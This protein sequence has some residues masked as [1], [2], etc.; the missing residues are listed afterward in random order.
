MKRETVHFDDEIVLRGD[1]YWYRGKPDFANA[2]IEKSLKIKKGALQKDVLRAKREFLLAEENR[3][4]IKGKTDFGYIRE[5]YIEERELEG[6]AHKTIW[7]IRHVMREHFRYFEKYR[8][9][10]IDQPLFSEYCKTKK[11][12]TLHVH[13]KVLNAFLKWCTQNKYLKHRPVISIPKFARKEK[14]EREVLKDSEI[15]VLFENL[16]GP[17]TLYH[18]MY[19]LMGMRNSEILKL[20]WE[21]VD[22]VSGAIRVHPMTN[23]SRKGRV[24]PINPW[25]SRMLKELRRVNE[26]VFPSRTPNGKKGH[27]DA[28][29]AFRKHWKRALSVVAADRHFTPHDMRATFETFMHIND[30]F[31]DTQREKMAGANI[32]VQKNIYVTMDVRALRGLEESVKI[33]GLNEIM[34]RKIP[35]ISGAKVGAKPSESGGEE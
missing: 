26:Y 30:G 20:K 21:D 16:S 1:T 2:R 31:T 32:D 11:K 6:L 14:R 33:E 22:L 25:V 12:L 35:S 13:R 24:V 19:L 7:E 29:G 34:E 28:S 15:K 4:Y 27:R 9:E 17:A 3:G 18:A 5:K 8:I 10:E 23:K